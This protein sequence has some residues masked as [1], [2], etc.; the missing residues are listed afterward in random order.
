MPP[1][2]YGSMDRIDRPGP[3][4]A[5]QFQAMRE[6]AVRLGDEYVDEIVMIKRLA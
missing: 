1:P 4:N 6:P 3:D 2:A 5:A